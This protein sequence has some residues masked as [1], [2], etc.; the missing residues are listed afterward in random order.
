MGSTGYPHPAKRSKF[1]TEAGRQCFPEPSSLLFG[2]FFDR[3]SAKPDF[4]ERRDRLLAPRP[5]ETGQHLAR[6]KNYLT[7]FAPIW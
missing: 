4:R 5:F 6:M 7:H 1:R 2:V 3:D